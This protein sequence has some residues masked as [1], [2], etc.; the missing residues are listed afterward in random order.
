M[1]HTASSEDLKNTSSSTN[2]LIAAAESAAYSE[3][4]ETGGYNT[5]KLGESKEDVT[6]S[7]KYKNSIDEYEAQ[8]SNN[9]QQTQGITTTKQLKE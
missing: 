7:T 2:D 9:N 5:E 8:V 3:K 4:H 6:E 1:T